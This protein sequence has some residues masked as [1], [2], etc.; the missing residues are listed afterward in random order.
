[1]C[2]CVQTALHW[3]AK[4]G[5]QEA[6]DTMLRAGADVN[7]R[8]VRKEEEEQIVFL[9]PGLLLLTGFSCDVAF[10]LQP[11]PPQTSRV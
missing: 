8:S 5:H 11:G 6:V 7:I 2:L 10:L 4:Q 1:M 9:S 3:A